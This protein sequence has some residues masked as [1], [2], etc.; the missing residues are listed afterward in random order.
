MDK[1]IFSQRLLD[2][3]LRYVA[4]DT[5]SDPHVTDR[6]PS[7][8]N[9]MLLLQTIEQELNEMGLT[10]TTLDS[11][12]YLIGRL[13]S[14][15]PAGKKV[16][17]IGFMAHVDVADDVMGNGVKPTVIDNYDGSDI[18]LNKDIVLKV[19][20]N[21]HL[22]DYVGSQIV[23]TDGT[24]LLGGDD[25]AGVAILV[26]VAQYFLENED[27]KHGEIEFIFTT[28]EETGRGMDAFDPKWLNSTCCYTLDGGVR[29]EVEAECF[30]AATVKVDFY[31]V[32]QHLGAA[33]AKMVNSVTMATKFV[34]MLPQS[35]S[36]EATDGRFGYYC[37]DEIRG[38]IGHTHLNLHIRDFDYDNLLKR[39]DNL[40]SLSI[41]IE[42]LFDGG[43]VQLS[44]EVVYRNMYDSIK[45]DSRV[46]K[47]IFE[48]AE[49]LNLVL[50][51]KIIR[52]GTD[53]ARLAE[54]G[55]PTPN[56]FTG[57][58]NLHSVT[59]WVG[60]KTMVDSAKLVEQIIYW[61][62]KT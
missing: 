8:E 36:P 43:K 6:R 4:F 32:P 5:M 42:N 7:T 54:M 39:I 14:N 23:V 62:A 37:A 2:R 1:S 16:D 47:A 24:T 30:N 48:A 18:I 52:G 53:G 17:T 10:D 45:K 34:S 31:G 49:K 3:F 46:M 33:R 12:G 25:K 51:Q 20:E 26:S 22:L 27:L 19:E 61:W 59:E 11:N 58:H 57:S 41:A 38:T 44:S 21:R 9:Q 40:K 50:E 35:E 60:V 28:D 15:L 29:G 13:K 56:L 55:I